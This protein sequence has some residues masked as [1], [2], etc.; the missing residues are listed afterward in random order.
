MTAEDYDQQ[1]KYIG[2]SVLVYEVRTASKMQLAR[3]VYG[4]PKEPVENILYSSGSG[5]ASEADEAGQNLGI[6]PV[7]ES[8]VSCIVMT[9]GY[10]TV[11]KA[12]E[13]IKSGAYD[14]LMKPFSADELTLVVKRALANRLL[15]LLK[16]CLDDS[17]S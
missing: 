2:A 6:E 10:G 9:T 14:Y 17:I 16:E 11:E 3:M 13:A 7:Y 1:L 12:V 15:K 4:R 8:P 5:S